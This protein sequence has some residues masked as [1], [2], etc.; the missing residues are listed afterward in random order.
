MSV[1]PRG[2]QVRGDERGVKQMRDPNL[3]KELLAGALKEGVDCVAPPALNGSN[4]CGGA[5]AALPLVGLSA[6]G[7]KLAPAGLSWTTS[8]IS[9]LAF[10]GGAG[11]AGGGAGFRPAGAAG[12]P[13]VDA[14]RRPEP[15]W[16]SGLSVGAPFLWAWGYEVD[17]ALGR[18]CNPATLRRR[19]GKWVRSAVASGGGGSVCR[20]VVSS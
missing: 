8:N 3:P 12:E 13:T 1:A 4:A 10:G 11:A 16:T 19:E 2:A 9:G 18:C 5:A 20:C 15:R 6:N 7:S 14:R 17:E